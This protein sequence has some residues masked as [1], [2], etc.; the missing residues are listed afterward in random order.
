MKCKVVNE[1][2][3]L[4]GTIGWCIVCRKAAERYCCETRVPICSTNC[5]QKH[6][7]EIKLV[8]EYLKTPDSIREFENQYQKDSIILFMFICDLLKQEKE[9]KN[10]KILLL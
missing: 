5:K 8:D 9:G 10:G 6:L 4:C 2:M 3:E 1:R 7:E